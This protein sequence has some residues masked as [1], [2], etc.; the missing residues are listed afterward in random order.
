MMISHT[1]IVFTRY[2]LLE[3]LRR[4]ENDP[5][6][7]GGLFYHYSDDIQDMDFMTAALQSLMA[8]FIDCL[9]T[10]CVGYKKKN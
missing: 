8:L 7:L 1:T 5:K 6:T 10:G 9:K 2:I 4:N 3:W